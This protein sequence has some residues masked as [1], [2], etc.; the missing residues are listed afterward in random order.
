[1]VIGLGMDTN[2]Q[3]GQSVYFARSLQIQHNALSHM[4]KASLEWENRTNMQK[5]VEMKER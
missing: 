1:M 3:L 4:E 2:Q 5:E